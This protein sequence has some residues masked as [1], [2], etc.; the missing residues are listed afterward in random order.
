MS[1]EDQGIELNSRTVSLFSRSS[2]QASS[3]GQ[4]SATSVDSSE[5]SRPHPDSSIPSGREAP[6]L[7]APPNSHVSFV[8]PASPG[9]EASAERITRPQYQTAGNSCEKADT[10]IAKVALVISIVAIV[11]PIVVGSVAVYYAHDDAVAARLWAHEDAVAARRTTHNDS[12]NSFSTSH[13]D[14]MAQ[15]VLAGFNLYHAYPVSD[16]YSL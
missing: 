9:Q 6:A 11:M 12:V 8:P 10:W 13:K 1:N 14:A 4:D 15:P 16:C 7:P 5:L 2:S 3:L